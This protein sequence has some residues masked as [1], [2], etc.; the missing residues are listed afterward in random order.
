M[1]WEAW[2]DYRGIDKVFVQK[3]FIVYAS[4]LLIEEGFEKWIDNPIRPGPD[5]YSECKLWNWVDQLVDSHKKHIEDNGLHNIYGVQLTD[6]EM[7]EMKKLN[8]LN[9]S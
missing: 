5:Y 4:K 7:V 8:E 1:K 9:N 6:A 3:I 2:E